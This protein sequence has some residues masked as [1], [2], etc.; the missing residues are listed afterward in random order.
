MAKIGK[1]LKAIGII[2]RRPSLLNLIL[3]SEE[4]KRVEVVK[5]YAKGNGLPVVPLTEFLHA[6]GNTVDPFAFLDGGCIPTDLALLRALCLRNRVVDYLEIGTWRGE[7]VANVAATGASCITV[8]LPDDEMRTMGMN[9]DYIGMHRFF[10]KELSNVK[11][12]QAHSHRFDFS[13]LQKKFDLIFID[14]DHHSESIAKDTRTAFGLLKDASSMIVW[15][16]YAISPETPR[17]EVLQ[18][19]LDGLPSQEHWNL[20]HVSNTL[21]AIYT[22]EKLKAEPLKINAKPKHWFEIQISPKG[23]VTHPK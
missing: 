5:K 9:D 10:S 11:H 13:G 20:Y 8:N 19:I 7:S 14:G 18:G 21:C 3:D 6:E 23:F 2:L 15:H 22:K 17:F 12:I 1:A 16:D 4:I